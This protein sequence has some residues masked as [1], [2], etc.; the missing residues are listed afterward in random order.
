MRR[1]AA[2]GLSVIS[3][4]FA[5]KGSAAGE[6]DGVTPK[7]AS[8]GEMVRLH[9]PAR[10]TTG[11][12][13]RADLPRTPR[14][15]LE[16]MLDSTRHGIAFKDPQAFVEWLD[17][18]TEPQ[19]MTALATTTLESNSYQKSLQ[20]LIRPETARNW[21]E[22]SNPILYMRWMI[23]GS[24]PDFYKAIIER[25]VDPEKI[26]RWVH[27]GSTWGPV[28]PALTSIS[29]AAGDPSKAAWQRLPG[30]EPYVGRGALFR[31]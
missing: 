12:P 19:F 21:A 11:H 18:M 20:N 26:A 14:D 15:W 24:N 13:S 30:I 29:A 8:E 3:M 9:L 28:A 5:V 27:Y 17:A 25:L 1:L 23:T 22:F 4:V 2:I 31:Y 10:P 16:R 6:Q 7:I